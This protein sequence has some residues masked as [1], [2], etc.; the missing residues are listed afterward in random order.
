MEKNK[1]TDKSRYP[2]LFSPL[3]V[4]TYHMANRLVALPVHTG[5]AHTDGGASPWMEALYSR[6]ADSGVGMVIVANAAVSHDGAVSSFNLRADRDELIP[7]LTRLAREIKQRGAIACLQLN[8]AGRFAKTQDP[9]LPSPIISANLSFN[10][11]SLKD[12]MHFF[13]FEKRFKLTRFFI[14]QVAKWR[15]AMTAEDRERVMDDFANAALRAYQAGFDMVELHGANGY[16]LCQYLSAFTNK[17]QPDSGFGGDFQGRTAFPLEVVKRVKKSLPRNFPVGFRLILREWVPNGID[18]PEALAFA[19]LLE[20]EGVAYLSASVGTYNSILSPEILKHMDKPA[21]LDSD[22]AKLTAKVNIPTIISGRVTTPSQADTLISKGTADLIGLGRSLRTDPRWV[23][24][25]KTSC[26]KIV[27]CSNCNWCLKRVIL[28]KGFNCR[29]W[30]KLYRE[31]TKLDHKMLTRNDR[32]LWI[33]SST[34]EMQR[35]TTGQPLVGQRKQ[36]IPFLTI[37]FLPRRVKNG[38]DGGK[39]SE[40]DAARQE[41]IQYAR[42]GFDHT[43]NRFNTSREPMKIVLKDMVVKSQEEREKAV[44]DEI[45]RGN[46]GQIVLCSNS[47]EFWRERLLYKE[48]GKIMMLLG[49]D[50]HNLNTPPPQHLGE[51]RIIIPVDLSDVTLILLRFLQQNYMDKKAFQLN[52]VHVAAKHSSP[53]Q[54]RWAEL[55]RVAGIREEIPLEVIITQADVVSILNQRIHGGNYGTVVMGKRGLSGIKRWLLGSVSAGVLRQLTGQSL[56]LID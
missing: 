26:G 46:H 42:K 23:A 52:F 19:T 10:M 33:I 25:A 21:Y 40:F 43:P 47:Q 16:L 4:G 7:G 14:R 38:N 55:K 20:N 2:S 51:H 1:K 31:R 41:F 18:L 54:Q 11:E 32:T 56:I 35:F 37:L 27:K 29:L 39:F 5:F 8:H 6:L 22:V 28:E 12:F 48:R 34:N 36:G 45:R 50:H 24:K 9:L 49:A 44:L 17:L 30:P 53:P 3:K 15:H 13:P